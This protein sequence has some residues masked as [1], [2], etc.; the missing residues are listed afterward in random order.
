MKEKVKC[1]VKIEDKLK[2]V[3]GKKIIKTPLRQRCFLL[4]IF[5]KNQS[6]S[7]NRKQIHKTRIKNKV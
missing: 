1:L 5:Y 2:F 7:Y 3:D 4:R 6:C